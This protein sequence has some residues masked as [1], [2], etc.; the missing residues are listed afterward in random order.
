MK[1]FIKYIF[2][3]FLAMSC[4]NNSIEKPK[5]PKNL[6]KKEKMVDI[7]I[8]MSLFSAAKGVNKWVIESNGILP[9][10]YIYRKYDIDSSQFAQSNEYY[11]YNLDSY[12]EIYSKVKIR[13]EVQ[14]VYYDSIIDVEAKQRTADGKELRKRRDSLKKE[15]GL[16]DRLDFSKEKPMKKVTPNLVKKVD[17]SEQLIRQ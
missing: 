13:L 17:S 12:E 5:K 6:I 3:L 10:D 9:E 8:D 1:Y 11:A 4:N 14:K 7:I 2:I 16:D 15:R